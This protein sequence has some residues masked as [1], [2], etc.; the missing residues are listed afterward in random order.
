MK[1]ILSVTLFAALMLTLPVAAD[2][3]DRVCR[4]ADGDRVPCRTYHRVC[5]DEDGDRVP[6]GRSYY[7]A[8]P[9]YDYDY[10]PRYYRSYRR[11]GLSIGFGSFGF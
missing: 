5:R 3:H 4:D 10:Q 1:K 2:A 11:P 8:R 6:C 7:Y 9:T